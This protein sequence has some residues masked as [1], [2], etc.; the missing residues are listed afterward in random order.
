MFLQNA[1]EQEIKEAYRKLALKYHPNRN[2]NNKEHAEL[3]KN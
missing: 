2:I 1:S 3:K